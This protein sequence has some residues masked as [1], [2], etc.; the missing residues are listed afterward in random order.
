VKVCWDAVKSDR[1]VC[2]EA[3]EEPI[4]RCCQMPKDSG[5]QTLYSL[6]KETFKREAT[7]RTS[8][9]FRFTD[10]LCDSVNPPLSTPTA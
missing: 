10:S 4:R 8:E 1:L 5:E 7:I 6:A 9:K 3:G 2:I